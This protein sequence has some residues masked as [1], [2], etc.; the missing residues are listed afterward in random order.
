[1]TVTKK[2]SIRI[3]ARR[4]R[5][6]SRRRRSRTHQMRKNRS[7][8]RKSRQKQRPNKLTVIVMQRTM[9]WL[10]RRRARRSQRSR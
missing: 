6:G 8:W 10:T 9:E 2:L 1:M 4:L 5:Q 7:R 3:I